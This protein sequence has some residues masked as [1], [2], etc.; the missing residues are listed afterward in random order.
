M[1]NN[2]WQNDPNGGIQSSGGMHGILM[3]L[4]LS[5]YVYWNLV[6]SRIQAHCG[7][8]CHNHSKL[9]YLCHLAFI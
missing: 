6:Y 1:Q 9:F 8:L 2:D 5:V 7:Y 4:S 3:L